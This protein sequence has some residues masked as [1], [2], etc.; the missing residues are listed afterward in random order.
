MTERPWNEFLVRFR[1]KFDRFKTLTLL[2]QEDM[3]R[4]EKTDQELQADIDY[5][6]TTEEEVCNARVI[7]GYKPK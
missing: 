5:I 6:A 4:D 2:V 7:I 1:E 3:V